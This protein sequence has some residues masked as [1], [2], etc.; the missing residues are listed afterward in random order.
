MYQEKSILH[1]GGTTFCDVILVSN[2]H[3]Y[4]E[5]TIKILSY[6]NFYGGHIPQEKLSLLFWQS[7]SKNYKALGWLFSS[8]SLK[9]F[10]LHLSWSLQHSTW[11]MCGYYLFLAGYKLVQQKIVN[12]QLGIITYVGKNR[13]VES[14]L[15]TFTK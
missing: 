5:K 12:S 7:A 15:Q 2:Y 1:Q 14:S 6:H 10:K 4:E 11:N 3:S 13:L 8:I 9:N